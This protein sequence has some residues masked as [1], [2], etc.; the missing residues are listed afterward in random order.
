M[1]DSLFSGKGLFGNR[2]QAMSISLSSSRIGSAPVALLLPLHKSDVA[3]ILCLNVIYAGHRQCYVAQVVTPTQ[4][5][6]VP[7]THIMQQ[8]PI[9]RQSKILLAEEPVLGSSKQATPSSQLCCSQY[10]AIA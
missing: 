9:E 8:L 1:H 5:L 7:T 4:S 3:S 2:Q 10:F 6:N